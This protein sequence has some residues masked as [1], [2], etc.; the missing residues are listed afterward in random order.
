MRI[1]KPEDFESK[2]TPRLARALLGKFLV[3]EFRGKK[4][5]FMITETE[6]YDGPFD[7][8]N[9]AHKGKTS[10]TGVMFGPSGRWYVYLVYGMHEM[11]NLVT[12]PEGYPAAILIRGVKEVSGPGRLTRVLRITRALN[13][14]V[15]TKE[16]GLYIV[17]I[18][19]PVL[20]SKIVAIPR[21]GVSYAGPFWSNKPYRFFIAGL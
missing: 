3:R 14:K 7:R 4:R 6:A 19:A 8:A 1:L 15:F 18:G 20:S 17:D 12:G 16:N 2:D 11:L 21:I 5:R 10:R 13:A 9:H